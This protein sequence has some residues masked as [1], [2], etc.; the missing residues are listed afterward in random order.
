MNEPSPNEPPFVPAQHTYYAA[1]RHSG[2]S[3]TTSRLS[4][5]NPNIVLTTVSTRTDFYDGD[6]RQV[7][8]VE[9]DQMNSNHQEVETAY[10]LRSTC[11]G[12]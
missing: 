4:P 9:T 7:K 6:G 3:Q 1:G 11:W 8:H 2:V 5:V 12:K 10:Y